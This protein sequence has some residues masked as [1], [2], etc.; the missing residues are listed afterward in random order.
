MKNLTQYLGILLGVIYGLLFRFLGDKEIAHE[1]FSINSICFIWILPIIIS[2]FPIIITSNEIY[3][4]AIKQ[5]FYPII[6]ILVFFISLLITR[7]EDLFCI[8]IISIPYIFTAGLVGLLFGIFVKRR[9]KNKKLYSILILPIL[10]NPIE[11]IFPNQVNH[12]Q[13]SSEIIIERSNHDIFP[14]ILSVPSISNEEYEEG[15][16]QYI[17][18]P[19]PLNSYFY[20]NG[21]NSFR[22]GYFTNNLIL[23]EYITDIRQNEYVNFKIDISK[24]QLRDTPTDQHIL[25]SNNFTFDNINYTLIPISKEATKVI[26]NCDYTI[27]SKMNSYANF[28]AENVIQDF[29]IR[30]LKSL[31]LIL[32]K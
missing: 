14:N 1:M 30:L 19:R 7:L 28:W 5:F 15:F 26:L 13:V 32:E 8:L 24:S 9:I 25:K 2:V 16:Y 4:S 17:G 22:K 10:L 18:I 23:H 3:K 12:Y 29:E 21:P 6:T 31:K 20:E 27:S 11:N